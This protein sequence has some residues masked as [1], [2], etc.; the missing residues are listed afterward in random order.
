M[1]SFLIIGAGRFGKHLACDLCREG[2]EVML[3][4]N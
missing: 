1:H 2:H 4:D 3:V